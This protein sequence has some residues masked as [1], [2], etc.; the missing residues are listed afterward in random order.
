MESSHAL[1]PVRRVVA[2][3]A[4]GAAAGSLPV[5]V[6]AQTARVPVDRY[7][8]DPAHTSVS[9]AV[10]H[11]G[12][13][14]VRG[15]FSD[16][17]GAALWSEERP[18]LSSATIVIDVA[19]LD[20]GNER[21]DEDLRENFFEVERF[22]R[23][24]FESTGFERAED[25]YVLRGE[26]TIRDSTHEVGFPVELLGTLTDSISGERRVGFEGGLE[27][28]RKDYGV[29]AE[30]HPAELRLVIGHD[31]EIELQVE[32]RVPGYR[33]ASFASENG[34]S[35]GAELAEVLEDGGVEAARRRHAEI[36]AA[37]DGYD[38]SA[39]ELALLGFKRLEADDP[40][41]AVLALELYREAQPSATADEWLG[42]AYAAAGRDEEAIA[43]YERALAEDAWRTSAREMLRRLG[44]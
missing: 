12:L 26:L 14:K 23:I 9:F 17:D 24:T 28:D 32:A 21:R 40:D 4:I 15:S 22:P 43:A 6:R 8:V 18:E 16:V 42:H 44:G 5:D 2:L 31:I 19:T 27:I 1:H 29:E 30:G 11:L 20:T 37:P 25:G 36:M 3:L 41:G 34:R 10:R 39:R 33:A 13:S 38:T 7:V 35:I